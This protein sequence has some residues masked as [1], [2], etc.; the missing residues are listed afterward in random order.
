MIAIPRSS[1][2]TSPAFRPSLNT[3]PRSALTSSL[4]GTLYSTSPGG[5]KT[6]YSTHDLLLLR[7]SP[8]SKTPPVG[9]A[10][11]PGVTSSALLREGGSSQ[12]GG[13]S[14]QEDEEEAS[15]DSNTRPRG[16]D[17]CCFGDMEL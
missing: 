7:S 5:T 2:A 10:Y 17:T 1:P 11:I 3:P 14:S 6:V 9:L 16:S 15:E 4:G 8:L 13:S 12:E